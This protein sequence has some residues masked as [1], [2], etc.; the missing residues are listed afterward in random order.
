MAAT[1]ALVSRVPEVAATMVTLLV[2]RAPSSEAP[3][4]AAWTLPA[5]PDRNRLGSLFTSLPSEGSA[6]T[7]A[8]SAT[9][10]QAMTSRRN[11]TTQAASDSK[12]LTAALGSAGSAGP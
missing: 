2:V 10:Q 3:R 9:S 4:S 6:T 7:A 8:T 11:R 12:N 5:L 1:S